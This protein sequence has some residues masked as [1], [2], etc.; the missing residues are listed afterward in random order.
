MKPTPPSGGRSAQRVSARP[1]QV[2]GRLTRST[3]STLRSSPRSGL[4]R[5]DLARGACSTFARDARLRCSA[6]LLA[7]SRRAVATSFLGRGA[8]STFARDARLRSSAGLLARQTVDDLGAGQVGEQLPGSSSLE[9]RRPEPSTTTG[10]PRTRSSTS[11]RQ[12]EGRPRGVIPPCSMP[13]SATAR[14]IGRKLALR[15][16]STRLTTELT[17]RRCRRAPR[18]PRRAPRRRVGPRPRGSS[19]R[20]PEAG[21]RPPTSPPCP[22]RRGRSRRPPH[23]RSRT[24]APSRRPTGSAINP[25]WSSTASEVRAPRRGRLTRPSSAIHTSVIARP[26]VAAPMVG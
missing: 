5:L 8:C 20:P 9:R 10:T 22:R 24:T 15:T 25:G 16:S 19:R 26:H 2:G 18:R 12:V 17:S 3:R 13:D 21:R 11:S 7:G 1:P 6:G 23:A 4:T 14:S